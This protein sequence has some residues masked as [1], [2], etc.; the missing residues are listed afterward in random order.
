MDSREHGLAAESGKERVCK[1]L[2]GTEGVLERR[3]AGVEFSEVVIWREWAR[4][5]RA[6][7]SRAE[8]RREPWP[9]CLLVL[10]YYSKIP[11]SLRNETQLDTA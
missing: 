4:R 9:C 8:L 11:G 2:L 10:A 7:G 1:L 6:G 5:G 3:K